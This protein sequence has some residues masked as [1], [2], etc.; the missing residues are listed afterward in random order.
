MPAGPDEDRGALGAGDDL[1]RVGLLVAE[2]PA[3]PLGDLVACDSRAS[4]SPTSRPAAGGERG[5]PALDRLLA[6]AHRER[7]HQ[8]ALQRQDAA[9]GDHRP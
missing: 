4:L 8:P 7:R 2:V 9:L 5:E 3:D 1:E 6:G